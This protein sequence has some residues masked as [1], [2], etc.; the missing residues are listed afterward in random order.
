MDTEEK[1]VEAEA[2]VDAK[3]ASNAKDADDKLIRVAAAD[4]IRRLGCIRNP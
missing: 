3:D 1:A 2:E 4:S